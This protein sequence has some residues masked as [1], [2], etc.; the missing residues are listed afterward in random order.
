M[1]LTRRL[2]IIAF[3]FSA[4]SAFG[5]RLFVRH[6]STA[7]GLPQ[8]QVFAIHQDQHGFLWFGTGGGLSRYDGRQFRNYT[9]EHGLAS[10]VIRAIHRDKDQNLWLATDEGISCYVAQR[11]TFI[12]YHSDHIGQGTVRAIAGDDRRLWFA[13]A[14]GLT[15]YD[16][17]DHSF[18]NFTTAN[19]LP[20]NLV[21]AVTVTAY[22]KVFIG[23]N[24]GLAVMSDPLSDRIEQVPIPGNNK[25]LL[26]VEALYCDARNRIFAGTQGGVIRI[27]SLKPEIISTADGLTNPVIRGITSD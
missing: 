6:Y 24:Q 21:Q 7:E 2:L 22:G 19:G 18:T 25:L 4:I 10:N 5:Q 9:K 8:N 27:D 23:T 14:G 3:F 17:N 26:R 16:F 15:R 1:N 12:S 11:D 13:T 20:A